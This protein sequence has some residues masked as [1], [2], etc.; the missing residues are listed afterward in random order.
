MRTP[1]EI[2]EHHARAVREDDL[3]EIAS[4]Y[5]DTSVLITTERR[6]RGR[7]EIVHFYSALLDALP[8][9][10]WSAT[11]IFEDDVLFVRWRAKSDRYTVTDGVDTFVFHAG[12]I[13]VQ[14]VHA[15]FVLSKPA[16]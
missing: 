10:E 9:A 12:H 4:D 13:R 11:R 5:T 1:E 6:Y 14:T 15:S 2:L 7:E 3:D 8:E 16:P